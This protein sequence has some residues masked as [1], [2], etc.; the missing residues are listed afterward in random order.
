MPEERAQARLAAIVESADDAIISK[1]LDGIIE[2]WNP[3]A[4]HIFGYRAEEVVNQPVTILIPREQHGEEREILERIRRG[5]HIRHYETV[6]VRKDGRQ[7]PISLTVSPIKAS[8][9]IVGASKIARDI[10]L[11][12]RME[13]EL[14]RAKKL[15]SVALLAGGIAHDFNNLLTGLYG[16]LQ[17]ARLRLADVVEPLIQAEQTFKRAHELTS[18]LL[19]F[20]SGGAPIRKMACIGDLLR[21]C[22]LDMPPTKITFDLDIAPDLLPTAIDVHQIAQAIKN[23]LINAQEAMPNGGRVQVLAENSNVTAAR[24]PGLPAGPYVAIRIVDSGV[25]IRDDHI[26]CIFDPYFTTKAGASGLG[27]SVAYSV[28]HRHDGHIAV[29]SKP[30]EGATFTIYLPTDQPGGAATGVS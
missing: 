13:E 25:G 5:E 9:S 11:R 15:E 24:I 16:N 23:L 1:N 7:I 26:G 12:R 17:L 10:T 19:T 20:S 4:E 2:T 30:G 27:L 29:Q 18:R 21:Q 8:G 22:V 28:I 3:A 6:R 14:M